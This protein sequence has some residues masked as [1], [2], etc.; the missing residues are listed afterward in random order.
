MTTREQ[1]Q[2]EMC[3]TLGGRAAEEFIFHSIT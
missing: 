1:L 3:A 2:D